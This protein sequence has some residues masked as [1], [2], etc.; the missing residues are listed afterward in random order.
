MSLVRLARAV[1][2]TAAAICLSGAVHAAI[3]CGVTSSGFSTAYD[4]AAA[5][6]NVTQTFFTVTCTRALASDPGTVSYSVSVDNGLYAL[7]Q[8]N[9]AAFAANRIR[10][11]VFRDAACGTTWKG[12]QAI[13]D[14]IAF[15]GT[16]MFGAITP[17]GGVGF[18]IGWACLAFFAA[19]L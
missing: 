5:G 13:S 12:N 3:T 16:G 6:A 8:N 9:R 4:P 15:T 17:I 1:L 19:A 14:S 11:D 10:Y 2:S 18:L 7:G